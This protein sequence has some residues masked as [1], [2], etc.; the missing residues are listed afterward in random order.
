[1]AAVFDPP[2]RRNSEQRSQIRDARGTI[3]FTTAAGK[4]QTLHV[5]DHALQRQLRRLKPGD[6]VT[7]T[8]FEPV[9]VGIRPNASK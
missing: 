2:E 9:A 6:R 3:Q 4:P 7:V 1:V 8:Y 5:R